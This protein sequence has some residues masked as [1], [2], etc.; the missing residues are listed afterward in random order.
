MTLGN[1]LSY[2]LFLVISKRV[3]AEVDA[4][5]AA[6]LLLGFGALGM[7]PIGLASLGGFDPALVSTSTW[8]LGAFIVVFPTAAAYLLTCWALAR[9]E[10][11]VVAFFIYL[12]PA[13]AASLSFAVLG[14][15]PSGATVAGAGLVFAAVYLASTG[16]AGAP[17][18]M[19]ASSSAPT[20][21]AASSMSKPGE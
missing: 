15:R 16:G 3:M 2:A 14:E 7:L 4:L 19:R 12:Q 1:A 5:A 6:A 8:A 20:G 13:I 18:A 9:V 10:S 17:S 11:S 21:S